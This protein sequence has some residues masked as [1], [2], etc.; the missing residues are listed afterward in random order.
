[1]MQIEGIVLAGGFSSR[2]GTYK[3][4]LELDGKKLIEKTIEGMA[5]V[6]SKIYVV[7][8]YQVERLQKIFFKN[9][10]IE[11]VFNANYING[12]Y[13]SIQEGVKHIRGERFFIMPGDCPL[14][15]SKIYK[16]LLEIEGD[17]II[18]SFNG[19]KGHPILLAGH[20]AREI[21]EDSI[22]SNLRKF[23]GKHLY[24]LA[25]VDEESILF[26]VDTMEDYRKIQELYQRYCSKGSS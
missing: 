6:C 8:G 3:M 15:S 26:D 13:S 9:S 11:V 7:G 23:I 22:V 14:V 24:K 4:E 20:L 1:M 10:K 17:I 2:V 16:H 25:Q 19:R 5:E 12:M 21:L 18:P